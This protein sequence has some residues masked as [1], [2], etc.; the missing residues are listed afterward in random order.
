MAVALYLLFLKRKSEDYVGSKEI[1]PVISRHLP[2]CSNHPP[3]I[4]IECLG[5][6]K[7]NVF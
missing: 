2:N 5:V 3:L 4:S 7:H 1:G 6:D